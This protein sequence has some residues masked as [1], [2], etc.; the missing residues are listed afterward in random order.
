[1]VRGPKPNR[2]RRREAARL[3]DRG[4]TLS[5]IGWRLGISRQGVASILRPLREAPAIPCRHCG[6]A[7]VSAGAL[8]SDAGKALC[9]GCLPRGPNAAFEQRLKT[10]R[11]AAGLTKAELARKA[12]VRQTS[13]SRYEDGWARPRPATFAS[14][15]RALGVPSEAL[16][17]GGPVLR[18]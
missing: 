8:P 12:G 16:M 10:F 9:L 14:L 6:V 5:E 3:R 18:K 2:K 15:A 1:M 17:P 13:L 7:I 4:L 11:L